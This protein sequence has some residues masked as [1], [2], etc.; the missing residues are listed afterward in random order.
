MLLRTDQKTFLRYN[1][2]KFPK[3]NQRKKIHKS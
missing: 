1:I 3:T 2:Q